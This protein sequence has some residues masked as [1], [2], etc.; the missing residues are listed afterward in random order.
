MWSINFI[1]IMLK[2]S[3]KFWFIGFTE[4]D[5]SF[6]SNRDGYLEFKITQ[7]SVDAQVLFYIKKQLGFGSVS[8]QDKNNKTHHFRVRDKNGLYKI[9]EIFNGNLYTEKRKIQFL[10]WVNNFNKL[11]NS[12]IKII[13]STSSPSLDNAWISGFT[14]AEGCFTSSI[15]K[16]S[17]NYNQVQV[18]YILS[19]KGEFD[20]M[21]KIATLLDG[22][23]S[24]LK[25]Y[26]GY[27]MTVN[28]LNLNKII[29][30][31]S[32]YKLKTKKYTSYLNWLKIYKEVINKNHLNNK[33]SII[34]IANLL[35]KINKS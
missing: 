34:K 3:F 24:F 33:S 25:S 19:Q 9:I 15:I 10:V 14:D 35:A 6:I 2:D 31:L 16:R 30:Y 7:S 26:S 23:V 32:I 13:N 20:L 18:R 1:K 21:L 11:Y 22:K 4:G 27:N 17:E 8:I 5:G 12:N 28:L 29:A